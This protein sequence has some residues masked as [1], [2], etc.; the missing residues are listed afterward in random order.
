MNLVRIYNK[1]LGL[2]GTIEDLLDWCYRYSDDYSDEALDEIAAK[3][4]DF[5]FPEEQAMIPVLV[6]LD[7]HRMAENS[8]T[9]PYE[10]MKLDRL[11]GYNIGA[12]SQEEYGDVEIRQERDKILVSVRGTDE[13]G[14]FT[15]A[16]VCSL[17]EFMKGDDNFLESF[18]NHILYYEKYYEEE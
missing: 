8:K 14:C 1:D 11:H 13:K 9:L 5:G 7:R 18:V 16:S 2:D 3:A 17:D 12:E 6:K 15:A 4:R 10:Q